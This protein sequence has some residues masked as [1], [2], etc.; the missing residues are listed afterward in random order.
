MS[1]NQPLALTAG[2]GASQL[3]DEQVLVDALPYLDTEYNEA[4]RQ[5]AMKLIEHECK[6]FRPTKNYLT[7]LTVPDYDAFL[8]PCML[9]EMERMS[10]KQE[11]PKLDMSRCELPPPSASKGIDRKMW[12]KVLRNAKAQNEHLLLRQINLELMDEYSAE[13]YLQRNKELEKL[14]TE[15]EKELRKSKEEVMEIHAKRKMSQMDAGNKLKQLENSWVSMVTNNYKMELANR[16]M[17]HDN[18]EALKKLKLDP[19]VLENEQ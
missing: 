13:S 18:K 6:T 19:S 9:K 1:S 17:A 11:M 8:S 4:D 16:Q 14:L 15:A 7:H 10:K 2:G 3:Q 5:M 12:K